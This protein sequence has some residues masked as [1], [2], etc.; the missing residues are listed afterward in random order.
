MNSAGPPGNSLIMR[1]PR[2]WAKSVGV[3]DRSEVLV[4]FGFGDVLLVAAP[5][6]EAEIARLVAAAGG[7]P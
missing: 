3:V 1:L 6:R 2:A 4:A 7:S 5:G